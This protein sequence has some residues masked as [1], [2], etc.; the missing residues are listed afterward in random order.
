MQWY[1]RALCLL[2]AAVSASV[3]A[4]DAQ[5]KK[6][7]CAGGVFSFYLENDLFY[8]TDRNY[9]SGVKLAWVSPNLDTFEDA[10]CMPRWL[11]SAEKAVREGFALQFKTPATERNL[12]AT[13]GQEIYSPG[14]PA[15]KDVIRSDRP[16][17]GWLYLGLGYNERRGER[18]AR[19][20]SLDSFELRLGAIGP[21]SLAREAQNL[22]HDL[23]GFPR[24]Q[25]WDNQLRNEPGL[26]AIWEHKLKGKFG[27]TNGGDVIGHAG[28]SAG[29]VATYMNAG[30][31]LRLGVDVPQ[32][33]GSSPLRPAGNNTSPGAWSAADGKDWRAHF[34]AALD[35]RAVARDVFLDGNTFVHS[36][37]VHKRPLVA[38]FAMGLAGFAHG[39]KF[40]FARVLRSTE[41]DGQNSRHSYG[42]FT[43]SYAF[44]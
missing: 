12:V 21:V 14:D 2:L 3:L 43:V 9:T 16:Y 38:D 1:W 17:A 18:A 23:R 11:E 35:A 39:W 44:K 20:D 41:F 36:H 22:I 37:R 4:D 7:D 6:T 24:F 34:F 10:K 42:S 40:S 5:G 8:N 25:G 30:V 19:T 32:D 13:I 33:F 31:E 15:R 26:Q 28:A 27:N 29:N